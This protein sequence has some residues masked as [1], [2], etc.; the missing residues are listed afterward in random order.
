MLNPAAQ[1][2]IFCPPRKK[3]LEDLFLDECDALY[4]DLSLE[5]WEQRFLSL[6]LFEGA[7]Y[8]RISDLLGATEVFPSILD[9]GVY[10]NLQFLSQHL[11]FDSSSNSL[12]LS[13]IVHFSDMRKGFA[14]LGLVHHLVRLKI[15]SPAF[16]YEEEGESYL[17]YHIL[18]WDRWSAVNI[19]LGND[20]FH[21]LEE[22]SNIK[23]ENGSYDQVRELFSRKRDLFEIL[24]TLVEE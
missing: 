10:Q 20:I 1:K 22:E 6:E 9:R 5:N 18:D 15:F 2:G 8:R 16:T 13:C 23:I 19:I 17:V 11:N 24:K 12:N 21:I 3:S 4:G 14:P 7:V